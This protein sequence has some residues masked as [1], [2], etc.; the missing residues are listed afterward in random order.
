MIKGV[1]PSCSLGNP[2]CRDIVKR[3]LSAALLSPIRFIEDEKENPPP[4]A[5]AALKEFEDEEVEE[6]H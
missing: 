2:I 3:S 4:P 1:F 6:L 5:A